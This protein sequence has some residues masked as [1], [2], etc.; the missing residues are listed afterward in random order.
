[1]LIKT[2]RS[3]AL[4]TWEFCPFKYFLS[5]N[6]GI[7]E[8]ANAKALHGTIC[9]KALEMLALKKLSIQKKLDSFQE[10]EIGKTYNINASTNEEILHDA[11]DLITRKETHID[12]SSKDFLRCRELFNKAFVYDNGRFNPL[13]QT[14]VNPETKFDFELKEPEFYYDF[15]K[16]G[17]GYL[18]LRGTMDLIVEEDGM[19]HLIDYKTGKRYN[20]GKDK[21]KTYKDLCKDEQL[22][23]YYFAAKQLHP[24][25]DFIVTIYYIDF[26]EP[27]TLSFDDETIAYTKKFL[28]ERFNEIKNTFWPKR[29]ISWKCTKL[30]AFGKKDLDNQ[31]VVGYNGSMCDCINKELQ[32][33]GLEK[34]WEKR[35]LDKNYQKYSGGGREDVQNKQEK[36]QK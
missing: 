10:D 4:S 27:I 35:C 25:K 15:G 29:K 31:P 21:E 6:L 26:D 28:K 5:Y 3:S 13:N 36:I 19:Y 24:D 30:C 22:C 16:H 20:W 8:P 14:I 18:R 12:W 1:M 11:Y 23:L 7:S 32:T 2:V 9:H 34:V 17:K 33:I